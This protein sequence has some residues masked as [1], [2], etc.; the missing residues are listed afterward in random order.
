MPEKKIKKNSWIFVKIL[1]IPKKKRK[2]KE[3]KIKY[4]KIFKKFLLTRI[5]IIIISMEAAKV[6]LLL[7]QQYPVV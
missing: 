4:L 6:L 3:L 5:N 7:L 2:K 1:C